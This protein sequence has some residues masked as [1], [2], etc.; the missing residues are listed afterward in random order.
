MEYLDDQ[1]RFCFPWI[2]LVRYQDGAE[3]KLEACE[4]L[5]TSV[6]AKPAGEHGPIT[7]REC[8]GPLW[9]S[10]VRKED[11]GRRG[12]PGPDDANRGG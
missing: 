5:A 1:K 11:Q 9:R 10:T 7:W 8:S 2:E 4:R 3:K 6:Q 12:E